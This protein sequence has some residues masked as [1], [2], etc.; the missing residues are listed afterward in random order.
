MNLHALSQMI[1]PS[2]RRAKQFAGPHE[3]IPKIDSQALGQAALAA[4]GPTK[5]HDVRGG[6][7][8]R[9]PSILLEFPERVSS[10]ASRLPG[11]RAGQPDFEAISR[12]AMSVIAS[13]RGTCAAR[14]GV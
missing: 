11:F 9:Q 3:L 7:R 4:A 12:A 13:R 2:D 6:M 5:Y 1:F 8:N 10:D 14:A